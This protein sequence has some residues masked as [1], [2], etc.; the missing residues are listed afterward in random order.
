MSAT[1]GKR[2]W[3][4]N[5]R[6]YLRHHQQIP[7]VV[8]WVP[9][10]TPRPLCLQQSGRRGNIV[11]AGGQTTAHQ[12]TATQ[13]PMTISEGPACFHLGFFPRLGTPPRAHLGHQPY[14]VDECHVTLATENPG[15][16]YAP[17]SIIQKPWVR[18]PSSYSAEALLK[19]G[20]TISSRELCG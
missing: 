17:L 10:P 3:L 1:V 20:S 7:R 2:S 11:M 5:L 12:L 19:G 4:N 8:P 18:P 13:S 15:P 14:R 9:S 16:P 6:R